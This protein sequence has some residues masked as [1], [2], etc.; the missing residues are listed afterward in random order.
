MIIGAT[1][2]FLRYNISRRRNIKIFIGSDTGSMILGLLL[3][4]TTI[5]FIDIFI[6][7]G[8]VGPLYHLKTAPVIGIAILYSSNY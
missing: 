2:G 8:R 3:V 4:F 1:L 5:E 7:K 6:E